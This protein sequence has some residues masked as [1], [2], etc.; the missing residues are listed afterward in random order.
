MSKAFGEENYNPEDVKNPV[1]DDGTLKIGDKSQPTIVKL[2]ADPRRP[3]ESFFKTKYIRYLVGPDPRKDG[4]FRLSRK[5]LQDKDPVVE[6]YWECHNKLKELKASNQ[7]DSSEY[8]K[9]EQLKK[10]YAEHDRYHLEVIPLNGNKPKVMTVV[11]QVKDILFGREA[12]GDK[13]AIKSLVDDMKDMKRSP[14]NLRIETGWLKLYKTGE[15]IETRYY[16]EEYKVEQMM[17][18]PETGE[19]E[20]VSRPFK[21]K[22]NPAIFELEIDQCPDLSKI[23]MDDAKMVWSYD[24]CEAFVKSQGTVVPERCL[25]KAKG[26][27]SEEDQPDPNYKKNGAKAPWQEQAD[28]SQDDQDNNSESVQVAKVAKV[29]PKPATMAKVTKAAAADQA[30]LDEVF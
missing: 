29:A 24:E 7:T 4:R 3:K 21:A 1:K 15:G 23:D 18:D 22:V 9:L 10:S 13:P 26:Q 16:A 28:A 8:R 6:A 19:E 12:W 2:C 11:G 25:K 5:M 27:K 17:K 20:S 14:F 30:S